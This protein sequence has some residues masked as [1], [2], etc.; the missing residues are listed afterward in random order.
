FLVATDPSDA[1]IDARALRQKRQDDRKKSKSRNKDPVSPISEKKLFV[2]PS[3]F[4]QVDREPLEAGKGEEG[5]LSDLDPLSDEPDNEEE[6]SPADASPEE[7][8]CPWC[9]QAV[10]EGLLK[11]F[12]KGARLNI[13]MQKRFCQKHRKQTA[14]DTWRDRGYP[15]IEW[16]TLYSRISEHK[17]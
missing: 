14:L 17:E 10:D 1:R 6:Q 12:S 2:M 8:L 7:T 11:K 5:A 4:S 3:S 15:E 9:G 16:G 13:R